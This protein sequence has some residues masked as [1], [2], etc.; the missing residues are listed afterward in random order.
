[1]AVITL[2]VEPSGPMP[3]VARLSRGSLP[4]LLNSCAAAA[5]ESGWVKR[6]GLKLGAEPMA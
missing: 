6:L 1:M 5:L 2:K 4:L 3:W